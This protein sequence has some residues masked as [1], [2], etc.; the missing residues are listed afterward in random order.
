MREGAAKAKCGTTVITNLETGKRIRYPKE[1]PIPDG[2][3]NKLILTDEEKA[4]RSKISGSSRWIQRID[5]TENKFVRAN[6][7]QSYLDTNEWKPG[8]CIFPDGWHERQSEFARSVCKAGK[9]SNRGRRWIHNA[10]GGERIIPKDEPLPEGWIEGRSEL[11]EETIRRLTELNRDPE[12][13]A[14]RIATL[15]ANHKPITPESHARRSKASKG[16]IVITD[17]HTEKRVVPDE[18]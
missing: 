1:L 5:G 6:E 11:P 9:C 10:N 15:K 12:R 7:V 14:R 13:I 3:V 8:R 16:R 18:V 4:K 2:W 17:G